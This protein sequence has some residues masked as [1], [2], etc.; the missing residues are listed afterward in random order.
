M[1]KR[2]NQNRA[3][4]GDRGER[5]SRNETKLNKKRDRDWEGDK[6]RSPY[7]PGKFTKGSILKLSS[8]LPEA[9]NKKRKLEGGER[10]IKIN[11]VSSEA[12]GESYLTVFI[13]KE[14]GT[15][16]LDLRMRPGPMSP[17]QGLCSGRLSRIGTI[18]HI[19]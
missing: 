17:A 14:K 10:G 5:P 4:S 11:T 16:N 3:L 2:E 13:S 1:I 9:E 7:G 8:E 19:I 12:R 18:E 15:F 6:T